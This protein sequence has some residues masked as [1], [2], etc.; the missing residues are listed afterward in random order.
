MRLGRF[1]F[2]ALL[3]ALVYWVPQWMPQPEPQP[4]PQASPILHSA[5]ELQ[6]ASG[7]SPARKDQAL[8]RMLRE[9]DQ[10]RDSLS[11][12]QRAMIDDLRAARGELKRARALDGLLQTLEQPRRETLSFYE[13]TAETWRSAH[14]SYLRVQPQA[15]LWLWALAIVIAALGL[16]AATRSQVHLARWSAKLG[17]GLSRGWLV[18][19][20]LLAIV[21]VMVTRTNPWPSFPTELVLPPI[22][23]LIGCA[24]AL[25]LVDLNY[26]VWN[27]LIRGCGAPLISMAF[28]SIYL[29]LV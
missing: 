13:W 11:A 1:I 23:A 14:E 4:A 8:K 5:K 16:A 28:S 21:L 19:L 10:H 18:I 20:S 25:R 27:S 17:V 24:M 26:P 12:E 22:V 7:S 3:I 2:I 15:H 29:K 9:A 6:A